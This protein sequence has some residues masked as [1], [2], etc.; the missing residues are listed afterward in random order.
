MR[1]SQQLQEDIVT[2]TIEE[3]YI[4]FQASEE[5]IKKVESE[6]LKELDQVDKMPINLPKNHDAFLKRVGQVLKS[7]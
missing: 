7:V 6:A 5:E 3:K 1:D 2:K 4:L